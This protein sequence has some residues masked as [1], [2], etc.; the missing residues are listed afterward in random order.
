[1][2]LPAFL[3]TVN[4]GAADSLRFDSRGVVERWTNKDEWLGWNF[5]VVRPGAY[6][7]VLVTSE[8][9][10]G[11]DWEGGHEVSVE[12]AGQRLEGVVDNEM[13]KNL[14]NIRAHGVSGAL[15]VDNQLQVEK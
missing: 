1:M 7:V 3:S 6:E 2:T 8:Q 4:K 5:R 12:V 14:V 10:Y 9:K 11:R 13:D 15:S